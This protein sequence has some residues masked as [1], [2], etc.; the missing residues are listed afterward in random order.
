MGKN[1]KVYSKTIGIFSICLGRA[2]YTYICY[3]SCNAG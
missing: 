1:N 3:R 2:L